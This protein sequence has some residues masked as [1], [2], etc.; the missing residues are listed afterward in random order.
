METRTIIREK[1]GIAN[2][3][4][5]SCASVEN[6]DVQAVVVTDGHGEVLLSLATSNFPAALTPDQAIMLAD[7]LRAS[8]A[9][10][11]SQPT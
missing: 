11:I 8:A 4:K 3:R 5:V 10:I 1:H 2:A 7:Q 9:R 6:S